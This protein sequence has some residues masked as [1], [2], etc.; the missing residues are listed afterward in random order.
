M[1]K[2]EE[3]ILLI[4]KGLS[5]NKIQKKLNC[6]KGTIYYHYKKLKGRKVKEIFFNFKDGSELGEFLGI[7]A[8]DGSFYKRIDTYIYAV[9]IHIGCYEQQYADYL[10][11]KLTIWFGKKPQIYCVFYRGKPSSY[12]FR[13]DSKRIY[14]L[15]TKYLKWEGRKTYTIRLK[16]LET[17]NK[18][19]NL[20]FLRGLI[21]TDGSYYAPKKRLS[22][23]TVSE[24]LAKQANS[25]I[26][27]NIG[28]SPNVNVIKKEDRAD[29]FTLTL[30]GEKAK[31]AI[32]A[33]KPSNINKT[34]T[35][36]V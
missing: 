28:F 29:L 11:E 5:I 12:I 8:G 16:K 24:Q 6:S 21:D 2:K 15:L 4:K 19:F 26:K 14:L 33:I 1:N 32:D 13:Y 23:S 7:F 3:I 34:H 17:K 35:A 27:N 9:K 31:N 10:K 22:F 18:T 36:V 20:G 25:I 30:H